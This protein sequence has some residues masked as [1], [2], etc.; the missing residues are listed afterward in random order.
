MLCVYCANGDCAIFP[1]NVRDLGKIWYKM[2][3]IFPS[4]YVI[5][6]KYGTKS[7]K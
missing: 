2:R 3:K 6:V 5:W 7:G 1:E 4:L